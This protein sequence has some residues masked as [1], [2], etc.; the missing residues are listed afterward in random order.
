MSGTRR[1]DIALVLLVGAAAFLLY[2]DGAAIVHPTNTAWL[3]SGD[4]AG[5][6]LGWQ[7]FR[8]T[9]L[10]QWPLGANPDL[11]MELGSSIVFSDSV[12]LLA[13]AFKPIA[14]WLPEA[15]QYFGVWLAACFLLQ[16]WFGWKI[17]ELAT[18][19]RW[20][21]L[22][23]A[24]LFA[25]APAMCLR[26]MGHYA[27][28]AHWLLLAGLYLYLRKATWLPAWLG[29][30]A[31]ATLV[32][33]YLLAM[34]LGLFAADLLQR[35][36]IG[37][38]G[39][40]RS[41]AGLG[42]ALVMVGL[43][44]WAAGYF[45]LGGVEG[46]GVG[47]APFGGYHMNLQSPIDPDGLWSRLFPDRRGGPDD[48][49]GFAYL[50]SGM[51]LL[52]LAC[53]LLLMTERLPPAPVPLQ[54]PIDNRRRLSSPGSLVPL[55]AAAA[56][57]M[58][59]ALSNHVAM[60][61]HEL[62]SYTLPALVTPFTSSFRVSG[63]FAWPVYYLLYFA[64][65]HVVATRLPRRSARLLLAAALVFQVVDSVDSWR[66]M[67]QHLAGAPAWQSPMQSPAWDSLAAGHRRIRTVPPRNLAKDWIAI[68]EF[69]S[70]HALATQ[71]GSFARVGPAR[72]A[73]AQRQSGLALLVGPIDPDAIY[74][75]EDDAYWRVVTSRRMPGFVGIV[76]GFRILAPRGCAGCLASTIAGQ[77]STGVQ[78]GA[79]DL[80]LGWSGREP[81]G[82]WSDGKVAYAAVGVP[83]S[84]VGDLQLEVNGP[85]FLAPSH[86]TQRIR[87]AI[88]GHDLAE[89]RYAQSMDDQPRRLRVPRN[90]VDAGPVAVVRF[91]FPDAISPA[92]AGVS[93]DP[94]MLGLGLSTLRL[95]PVVANAPATSAAH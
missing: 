21:A 86:P 61:E 89:L 50:G 47:N 9:P 3:M 20:S 81:W 73:L 19:D 58:V 26:L 93:A 6:W 44:M 79:A 1:W 75:F 14:R 45:M 72:E 87:V 51:L 29:L 66:H 64:I 63:R 78:A 2:A 25:I 84:A 42:A 24:A 41:V 85:A 59:I 74:V 18:R 56:G 36:W 5:S 30:L 55:L 90:M 13:F 67:G 31:V 12:P 53:P 69:A 91:E 23:G 33:A 39:R 22:T 4:P 16:A 83:S 70:R 54:A 27:L 40:L 34:C 65:L 71:A 57:F 52:L 94:R 37:Q 80:L 76:D 92:A 46:V 48:Y 62:F 17:S 32:H 43:L 88:N 35:A 8:L 77:P 49:E 82:T 15:F 28:V 95:V 7:F 68:G 11:G 10:L 38:R 60:G